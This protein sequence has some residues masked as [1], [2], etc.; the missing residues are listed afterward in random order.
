[1]IHLCCLIH[2]TRFDLIAGDVRRSK[3]N[4]G[5]QKSRPRHNY[6]ATASSSSADSTPTTKRPITSYYTPTTTT[7]T[8]TTTTE[9][10]YYNNNNNNYNDDSKRKLT[11]NNGIFKVIT[12]INHAL[13][14][15]WH[16]Q[17]TSM[18]SLRV[19]TAR[20]SLPIGMAGVSLTR[21]RRV[22]GPTISTITI[23]RPLRRLARRVPR[24]RADSAPAKVPAQV[25]PPAP[26]LL[27]QPNP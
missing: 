2:Y 12:Q 5:D 22:P 27:H 7:S 20:T 9:R 4:R 25:Q 21:S 3:E 15:R 26:Q 14:S 8:T 23:A 13:V 10:N 18:I 24:P 11:N 6:A 16:P 17:K 1:M 19:P